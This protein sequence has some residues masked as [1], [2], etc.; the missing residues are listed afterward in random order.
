VLRIPAGGTLSILVEEQGRVNYDHRLGEQKGLIGT[1]EI[2]GVPLTGWSSTP[3]DVAEIA[4]Q[5]ASRS[6]QPSSEA[7]VGPSAWV[8]DFDLDSPADLFL[9]TAAWSKGYAFVNGFFLGRYWRN[10]PTRTLFVPA[11]ATV[12]GANR[13]VVLE[14]EHVIDAIADFVPA[15]ALGDTEE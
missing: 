6:M 9:D 8:A 11:P 2:D 14:L 4:A 10:G 15:L 13:L 7:V 3:L 1:P 12:A 5:I